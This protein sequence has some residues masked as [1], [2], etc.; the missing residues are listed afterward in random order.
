MEN[1]SNLKNCKKR[2]TLVGNPY[3]ESQSR[4]LVSNIRQHTRFMTGGG[5]NRMILNAYFS[6]HLSE[7]TF[8]LI[9]STTVR[10]VKLI[11]NDC[12]F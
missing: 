4:G 7:I 9:E 12:V 10:N 11:V 5:S 6:Y 1:S 2:H 8:F 3:S